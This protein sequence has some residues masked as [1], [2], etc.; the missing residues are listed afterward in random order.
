MRH[1]V[2]L[3]DWHKLVTQ[4]IDGPDTYEAWESAWDLF[5]NAMISLVEADLGTLNGYKRGIE[6]LHTLLPAK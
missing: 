1:T 4:R 5:T 2:F 3:V 6:Q